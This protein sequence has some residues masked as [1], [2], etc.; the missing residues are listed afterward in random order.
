MKPVLE[1]ASIDASKLLV[2]VTADQ[3]DADEQQAV[4][5]VDVDAAEEFAAG[6][7]TIKD[8][9][10]VCSIIDIFHSFWSLIASKHTPKVEYMND[11]SISG[12][13]H[14]RLSPNL[15]TLLLDS[16]LF[17]HGHD[18]HRPI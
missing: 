9:C 14:T 11:A 18:V 13:Q 8:D 7:K 5:Q 15:S 3:K 17:D 10:Q 16:I 1:Q 4:V 6:V 2:Q 12:A